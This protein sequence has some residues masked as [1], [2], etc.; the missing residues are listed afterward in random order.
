MS[1]LSRARDRRVTSPLGQPD[2]PARH[3]R[4]RGGLGNCWKRAVLR[5]LDRFAGGRIVLSDAAEQHELGELGDP[6]LEAVVEVL[7]GRFYRQ[8]ALGGHLGAAEAYLRGWWQCDDLVALCRMFCRDMDASWR[9]EGGV[10]RLGAW[11]GRFVHA[12]R[13]NTLSGSRRNI[14]AHYDLGEDFFSLFLDPTMAYSCAVFPRPDSTLEEASREKFDRACRALR[15]GPGERLLEI[16]SGWGGLALHA[17]E[18]YRC[19]VTT[20]TISRRQFDYVRRLIDQRGLVDRVEVRLEDYRRVEGTFDKLVS[21]EMIEAVGWQ[22]LDTFFGVCSRC[23]KAD[24]AM[25]LQ[26]IL[27]PDQRYDRHRRSVDFIRYYVFPGGCLPSLGAICRALGR[28]TDLQIVALDDI[29]A[30]YA[31][32]LAQWRHRMVAN[33]DR[34]LALGLGEELLRLW[35]F[36]FCYCEAGFREHVIADAQMLL[37]KPGFA[38]RWGTEPATP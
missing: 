37:A 32:T 15:L 2:A 12:L 16:G 19:R 5:R 17:A 31:E 25:F 34:V 21:I 26:A 8:L 14:A 24:G 11:L 18:Q 13:R 35:E 7:D 33:T 10:A 9:M 29:T 38:R 27:M 20:V 23:L 3:S 28:A 36:Y 1:V 6:P 22:Y 4:K 30:H